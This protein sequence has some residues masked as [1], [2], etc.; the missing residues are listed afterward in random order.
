MGLV[1]KLSARDAEEVPVATAPQRSENKTTL[2]V[3]LD[4]QTFPTDE[5][6]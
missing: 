5:P 2:A 6:G 1:L 3:T 4:A